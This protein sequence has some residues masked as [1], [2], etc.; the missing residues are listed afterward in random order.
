M[1][2]TDY[3]YKKII[4]EIEKELINNSSNI[5]QKISKRNV[6]EGQ[7]VRKR[8]LREY[9]NIKKVAISN[10]FQDLLKMKPTRTLSGISSITIFTKPYMCSGS[11]IF[12]PTQENTPKS[13]LQD[14]PG[15]QRALALDY[16]PYAQVSK[17][18]E[19]LSFNGHPTSKIELIVSGGTW[20][21]YPMQYRFNYICKTFQALNGALDPDSIPNEVDWTYL[22]KLQE[23]NSESEHR[24]TGLSIETR[25][26]K[27]NLTMIEEMRRFGVTKVQIGV[28]SLHDEVLLQNSRGHNAEET[29]KAIDLLRKNG[30]KIVAHWMCNLMGSTPEIDLEDFQLLF[31]PNS[32]QPDEMKVYPCSLL[33][34]T[35]LH[36]YYQMGKYEPY[37]EKLLIDLLAKCKTYVPRY[38]RIS[39]LFRDIPS[40]NIVEGN[41]KTNLRELVQHKMAMD[42]TSCNCIRCREVKGAVIDSKELKIVIMQ[43]QTNVSTEYFISQNT[44]DDKI[45]GFLRL[46]IYSDNANLIKT[47]AMIREIHVYG[48]S[49]VVGTSED[50]RAQH[51]GLGHALLEVAYN[52]SKE[53]KCSSISVISAVGT[54]KYYEKQ[55]FEIDK[56]FGY[57]TRTI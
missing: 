29:I 33:E 18:L 28:Q 15:I 39:R 36:K 45:A 1:S 32:V 2:S 27:I 54:W 52:I 26:D 50:G 20:D 13:Y 51:F 38:T 41:K 55:G 30:F 11:C 21:D 34:G 57:G 9:I 48:Q 49:T 25:P 23:K 37:P 3:N 7:L 4:V 6:T 44:P 17:R 31:A 8:D 14:E 24:C 19:A 40:N 53:Q 56:E 12:C 35:V 5:W 43:Y 22:R 16:D 47:K 10:K 42:G 46:A